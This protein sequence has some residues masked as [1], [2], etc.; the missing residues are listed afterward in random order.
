[1]AVYKRYK[2]GDPR[3]KKYMR[4]FE[5]MKYSS[6]SIKY[7]VGVERGSEGFSYNGDSQ[8]ADLRSEILTPRRVHVT[9][10]NGHVEE[11]S[12]Y[13]LVAL[14]GKS[15]L[16][17]MAAVLRSRDRDDPTK[18][19]IFVMMYGTT[20]MSVNSLLHVWNML[21]TFGMDKRFKRQG[22]I[23]FGWQRDLNLFK[24]VRDHYH[25]A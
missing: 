15:T 1:M 20:K 17:G 9:F 18:D 6:I 7:P 12:P 3:L 22:K 21:E 13:I 11:V 24:G 25:L 14:G 2:A 23:R 5:R 16:L 4:A 19:M 8:F 10:P